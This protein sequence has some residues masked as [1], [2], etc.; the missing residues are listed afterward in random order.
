MNNTFAALSWY[1]YTMSLWYNDV[2][3]TAEG[4]VWVMFLFMPRFVSSEHVCSEKYW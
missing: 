2:M 1:E 4:D 3:G